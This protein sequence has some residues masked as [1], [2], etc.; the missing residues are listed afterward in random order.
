MAGK[1]WWWW[2]RQWEYDGC[3]FQAIEIRKDK[4]L[5]MFFIR[6]IQ[7]EAKKVRQKIQIH[8]WG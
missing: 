2:D 8:N 1:G 7:N 5:A 3:L 6:T 4:N